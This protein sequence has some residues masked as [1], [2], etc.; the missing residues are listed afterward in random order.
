MDELDD[1]ELMSSGYELLRSMAGGSADGK[2][3]VAWNSDMAEDKTR[4]SCGSWG[5][6]VWRGRCAVLAGR[7]VPMEQ[8]GYLDVVQ[9][10]RYISRMVSF[11]GH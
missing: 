4:N 1:V 11:Q 2:G 10:G 9:G 8:G 6:S 5:R 7:D 3:V